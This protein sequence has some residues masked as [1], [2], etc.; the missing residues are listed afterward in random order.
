MK[1]HEHRR[2]M[3]ATQTERTNEK[4]TI[5]NSTEKEAHVRLKV[6][7]S[8]T[9][10]QAKQQVFLR[11]PPTFTTLPIEVAHAPAQRCCL[12][13]FLGSAVVALVVASVL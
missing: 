3:T 2:T 1:H 13:F 10:H 7:T 6:G 5:S 8:P 11:H 4:R 9:N 12:Y